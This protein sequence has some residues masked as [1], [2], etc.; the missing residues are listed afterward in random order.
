M[1]GDVKLVEVPSGTSFGEDLVVTDEQAVTR[2][3]KIY[4]TKRTIELIR[5]RTQNEPS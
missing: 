5:E 4:C 2:D 1:F 3:D